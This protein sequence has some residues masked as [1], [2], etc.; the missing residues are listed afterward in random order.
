MVQV[1]TI[2]KKLITKS[3]YGRSKTDTVKEDDHK[4]SCKLCKL[5]PT[6]RNTPIAP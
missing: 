5:I 1:C 4:V 2:V 6:I 3:M